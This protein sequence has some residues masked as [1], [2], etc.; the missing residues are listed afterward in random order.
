MFSFNLSTE[1]YLLNKEPIISFCFLYVLETSSRQPLILFV[2]FYC[3]FLEEY[4]PWGNYLFVGTAEARPTW[5][6]TSS[7]KGSF[8]FFALIFIYELMESYN[9][10]FVILWKFA[11]IIFSCWKSILR[12]FQM[13]LILYWQKACLVIM[14]V[15][16]LLNFVKRPAFS[17]GLFRFSAFHTNDWL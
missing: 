8:I 4:D 13:L 1:N 11:L 5:T 6:W 14:I 10:F 16:V 2:C 7:N 3:Y 12:P 17:S 9:I 15:H